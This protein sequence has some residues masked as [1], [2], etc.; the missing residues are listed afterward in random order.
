MK[1]LF[2]NCYYQIRGLKFN[3]NPEF[4]C[5]LISVKVAPVRS[6]IIQSSAYI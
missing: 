6:L 3:I 1:G 2:R 5:E 4:L